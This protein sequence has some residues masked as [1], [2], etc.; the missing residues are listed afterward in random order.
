MMLLTVNQFE[1]YFRSLYK[2]LNLYA[3]RFTEEIDDAEDIVQQAFV[4]AW[5]K[6]SQGS[7]IGNLKAYMY[8]AVHNRCLNY[9]SSRMHK[10]DTQEIPDLPDTSE[11]E[12]VRQAERDARLWEAINKLPPE[13]KKIFLMAKQDGLRY[14]DI[15]GTLGISVKT[16][17][18]QMGKALKTLRE[19]AIKIYNFFF[20]W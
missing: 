2:P 4:D 10:A 12:Q 17:E 19:T 20:A 1:E 3:L 15:A 11:E 6:N 14:Q 7:A 5:E 13:R 9:L 18:N 16:V 8:Q